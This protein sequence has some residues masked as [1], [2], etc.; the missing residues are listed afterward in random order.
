MEGDYPRRETDE[1]AKVTAEFLA[2]AKAYKD[3]FDA[4]QDP[5]SKFAKDLGETAATAGGWLADRIRTRRGDQGD[6]DAG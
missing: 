2:A 3:N 5:L 4:S 1:E 6:Q